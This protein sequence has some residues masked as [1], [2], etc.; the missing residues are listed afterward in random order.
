[1]NWRSTGA[2]LYRGVVLEDQCQPEE[3]SRSRVRFFDA[4]RLVLQPLRRMTRFQRIHHIR[5]IASLAA[6]DLM[7]LTGD[8]S[9]VASAEIG[10]RLVIIDY[11]LRGD[12]LE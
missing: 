9:V 11:L 5:M 6:E 3:R 8:L 2:G 10:S 7:S 1:M 4:L 12:L